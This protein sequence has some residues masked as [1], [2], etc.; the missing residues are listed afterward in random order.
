MYINDYISFYL[1]SDIQG[2]NQLTP[3][4][5]RALGWM[6]WFGSLSLYSI[7][8]LVCFPLLWR[9]K[10]YEPNFLDSSQLLFWMPN[11]FCRWDAYMWNS[12]CR[13]NAKV[14]LLLLVVQAIKVMG[15]KCWEVWLQSTHSTKKCLFTK[16]G[17]VKRQSWSGR[18]SGGSIFRS[19][20]PMWYALELYPIQDS[21]Y[22]T[23]L[24]ITL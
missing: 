18:V 19:Q 3:D 23:V 1:L 2:L 15:T 17:G 20:P 21:C 10:G 8:L 13:C 12:E 9:L 7:C 6:T 16:C 14:I 5:C 11:R 4:Y 22:F 24:S